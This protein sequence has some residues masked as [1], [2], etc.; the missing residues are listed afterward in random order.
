[1]S[2]LIRLNSKVTLKCGN[3][4]KVFHIVPSSQ[5]NPFANMI[6]LDSPLGKELVR[7]QEKGAFVLVTPKGEVEYQ[8]VGVENSK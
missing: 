8:I 5:V 2:F 7:N 6:S 1:M 3:D 4:K